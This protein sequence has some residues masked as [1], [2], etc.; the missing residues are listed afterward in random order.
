MYCNWVMLC[1][2]NAQCD[3]NIAMHGNGN[4][5]VIT[6]KKKK[7]KLS[8]VVWPRP[9]AGLNL[10][11]KWVCDHHSESPFKQLGKSPKKKGFRGFNGIRTRGLCVSAAV[12]YQPELWRP[13]HWRPASFCVSFLSR[14]DDNCDSLRWSHTHFICIPAVHVISFWV[15]LK[16]S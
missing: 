2:V 7:K 10:N 9:K 11:L 12:L 13:I 8:C 16:L 3:V 6:E 4:K 14:V 1:N 15:N 5:N